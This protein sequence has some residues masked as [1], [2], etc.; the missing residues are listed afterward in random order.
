MFRLFRLDPPHGWRAVWWELAIVT[1]GV[2]IALVAQQWAE[3]AS[4][5]DRVADMKVRLIAEMQGHYA[6]A[7]ELIVVAPCID[8]QLSGLSR[9]LVKPGARP[10]VYREKGGVAFLFRNPERAWTDDAWRT[11]IGDGTSAHLDQVFAA[12]MAKHYGN[13]AQLRELRDKL[14]D[15]DGPLNVILEF[16][17][18]TIAQRYELVQR[19]SAARSWFILQADHASTMIRAID[20]A[21]LSPDRS[22]ITGKL[23]SSGTVRFC[24]SHGFPLNP[25]P[26]P[27]LS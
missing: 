18:P 19:V 25:F 7:A 22:Q 26:A 17:P 11:A 6:D 16:A 20:K 12:V 3:A 9:V 8:Q 13:V 1:L 24:R 4:W 5:R 21:G 2:L 10:Q 23:A 27:T 14:S 15:V